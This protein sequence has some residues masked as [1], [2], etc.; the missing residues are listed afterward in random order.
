MG[1]DVSIDRDK[2]IGGSDIPAIMG[3]SPFKTRY[4]LLLEKAGIEPN[5]FTGNIYTEYGT[6]MEQS[7]RD[8]INGMMAEDDDK[9]VPNRVI[10][11]DFRAHTDGFNGKCVLEIKCTSHICAD[12]NDYDPYLVQLLKYMEVNGV[13]EGLLAVYERPADFSLD[14]DFNRL[15]LYDIRAK[16][17]SNLLTNINA[18]I[19]RFRVDLERLKE[20]PLLTEADFQPMPLVLADLTGKITLMEKQIAQIE[21]IKKE[22][23]ATKKALYQAMEQNNVKSWTMPN[24]TKITRIDSIPASVETVQEFDLDSFKKDCEQVYALYLR[25]VEK[26]K[27]GKAGYVRITPA[28]G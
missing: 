9:Y 23:D 19:D 16:D 24:G 25:T 13:A 20:N 17:Y 26:K 5:T 22:C 6:K 15:Y 21:R 7:I 1:Y 11:G 28:K 12:V 27:S 14:F 3:I 8:Y 10:K 4:Q 2:Y 18:E